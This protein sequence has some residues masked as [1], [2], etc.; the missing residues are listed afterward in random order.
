LVKDGVIVPEEE[1]PPPTVPMDYT[2]ARVCLKLIGI[3]NII[4]M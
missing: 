1:V 3:F 4:I 2:W